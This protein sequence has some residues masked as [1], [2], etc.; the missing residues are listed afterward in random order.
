MQRQWISKEE[1]KEHWPDKATDNKEGIAI[2]IVGPDN[3]LKL[4]LNCPCCHEK[5]TILLDYNQ[6]ERKLIFHL[7]DK[8]KRSNEP[9]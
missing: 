8:P 5:I 2:D 1:A 3:D 6:M 7:E 9:T 4:T